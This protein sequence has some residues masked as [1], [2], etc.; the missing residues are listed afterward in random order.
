M[1]KKHGAVTITFNMA[2]TQA[3]VAIVTS[4]GGMKCA[5]S[6]GALVALAKKLEIEDPDIFVSASGSVGNM[7]YFLSKQYDDI[8]KVWTKYL[9]SKEFIKYLPYPSMKINYLV[10]T[11]LKEYMPLDMKA[12]EASPTRYFVPVTNLDTSQTKYISNEEWFNPYEV[13]RAAK[14]LPVLY[15]GHVR[16]GGASYLDGDFST[17]I[18][19]LIHK[20]L[21]A[22]AK[23]ILCIVNSAPPNQFTK[24]VMG[25][26]STFLHEELR[27]HLK[28]DLK[29]K[30]K[31]DFPKDV[32]FVCLTPSM[33]LPASV[34]SRNRRRIIETF[35]MGYDDMLSKRDDVHALFS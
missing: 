18:T 16:L 15:N 13:M 11:I 6:G 4:G 9:P 26:Y 7:F 32:Q 22:G 1:Q 14:A 5:Y 8:Q 21:E 33:H 31:I 24:I 34:F 35:N 29:E 2:R 25:A 19:D 23:R 10:D 28:K 3:K 17:S 12:L 27:N 30:Y 20:A